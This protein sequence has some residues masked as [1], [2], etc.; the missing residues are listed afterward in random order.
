MTKLAYSY[1]RFSQLSQS[2]GGSLERQVDIA[3][4]YAARKG[5]T[6]DTTLNMHDLGK[7]G[8]TGKNVTDGALGSFVKAIQAGKVPEG[9][10]LLIED[11][12][13][14]SR[15]PVMEAFAVFQSIINGGVTVVVLKNEQEYSLQSLNNEWVGLMPIFVSMG[16]ANEESSRKSTLLSKAWRKKKEDAVAH[17]TP[18][19]DSAPRWLKYTKKGG[20]EVI[21]DRAALV[22]RVYKMCIN[23]RG[24]G[25]IVSILNQEQ[26]PSFTGSTWATTTISRM[27]TVRT[28]LGEYQPRIGA[29]K[30]RKDVG[31]P[32]LNYFPAVIDEATF[33]AAQAAINSRLISR[34]KRQTANFNVWSGVGYC[35]L[36]SSTLIVSKKG[37]RR[38]EAKEPREQ[39]AYLVC[40]RNRKGICKSKPVRLEASEAV[41]RQILAKVGDKSL[42]EAESAAVSKKLQAKQGQLLL[43]QAKN[44][45]T[46]QVFEDEPS[47]AVGAVLAKQQVAMEALEGEINDLKLALAS[48]TIRDKAAFFAGLDLITF[49]GRAQTNALLKRLKIT[50]S[51]DGLARRYSVDQDGKRILDVID[52][53]VRGPMYYPASRE[54]R[55]TVQSQEGTFTPALQGDPDYEEDNFVNEGYDSRDYH[56]PGH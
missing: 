26:I 32:A 34:A 45:K 41:Y 23:G 33:N 16:R 50:V 13:R 8:Y 19:G 24:F 20:Y 21:K 35:A 25:S 11:I 28:V 6:L 49:E 22:L 46:L 56:P 53:P 9:S 47:R 43:D 42:A 38:K 2:K 51:I 39:L 48:D 55:T 30:A 7:S 40:T 4:E 18:L 3:Q 5:L 12:D 31:L 36:C 44:A 54:T 10:F 29:G 14:L 15:L 17:G 27:L 1:V 52:D 37:V